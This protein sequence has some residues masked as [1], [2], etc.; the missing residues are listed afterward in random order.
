MKPEKWHLTMDEAAALPVPEGKRSARAMA[1]GTM[2][3]R[4]F[5]PRGED[6]QTPH[7]QDE[8]YII[9]QGSGVFRREDER[10]SFKP[11]D[12]IFVAAGEDHRF[13]EF[14]DDFASWVVF[15]GPPGGEGE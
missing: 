13:E 15:W 5:V 9:A 1:H 4:W 3:L 10:V 7:D 8:I 12:A 14:S 2:E 11:G 6:I